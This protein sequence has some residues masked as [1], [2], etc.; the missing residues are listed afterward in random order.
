MKSYPGLNAVMYHYILKNNR[1]NNF[2]LNSLNTNKFM[3]QLNSISKKN[4]IISPEEFRFKLKKKYKFKN[5]FILTFDDGYKC[6]YEI[7]K[8]ILDLKNIKGFFYPTCYPYKNNKLLDINI[9]HLILSKEKNSEKL[10]N[11]IMDHLNTNQRKIF[12]KIDSII[13]KIKKYKSYDDEKTKIIKKLLQSYLPE[14]IKSQI[15]KL[16][17]FKVFKK[18]QIPSVN[19]F[20]LSINQIKKLNEEG[21]EIGLHGFKHN[22]YEFMNLLE[23]NE[24]INKSKIFWNN[25]LKNKK[26]W[27]L[28]YPFGSHNSLTKKLLKKHK[29]QFAFTTQKGSNL[30]P[31]NNILML[32]RWDTNDL[33]N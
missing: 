3:D 16:I 20:Y 27:S 25:I 23:Q 15:L 33:L 30:D 24:D 31:Y 7:V 10:L 13:K 19:N 18:T 1:F 9:I 26:N 17:I 8:K 11:F 21:H 22:R 12:L 14:K 28:C 5:E 6:N 32:K 4:K 29:I 2:T